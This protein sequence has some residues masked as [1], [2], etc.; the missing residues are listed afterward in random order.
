MSLP[1]PAPIRIRRAT[2][3]LAVA[4]STAAGCGL[5]RGPARPPTKFYVLTTSSS[6]AKIAI[7]RRLVI[8]LGPVQLPSYLERPEMVTRVA[9]NQLR[10]DEFSR[11]GESLKNNFVHVLGNELDTIL[12]LERVVAYPWYR[13]TPMDYI[14]TVSVSRF[15]TQPSGDVALDARW[16][17][18]DQHGTVL[19]SRDSHLSHPGG[20]S[21]AEVVAGLSAMLGEMSSE[22]ATSIRDTEARRK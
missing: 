13:G 5:L 9:P 19:V 16:G 22:I 10:F 18:A 1:T 7:A 12:D 21:P 20:S 6:P 3:A 11:W 15:E 8:G 14:V 2:V 17:I 4:L